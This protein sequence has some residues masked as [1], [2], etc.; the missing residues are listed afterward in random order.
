MINIYIGQYKKNRRLNKFN[1]IRY[2]TICIVLDY[3]CYMTTTQN[4]PAVTMDYLTNLVFN[5]SSFKRTSENT[6]MIHTV[7]FN[8]NMM[9]LLEMVQQD[10]YAITDAGKAAYINQ[11]YH[12]VAANLYQSKA[13]Q[14]LSLIAI[15][16]ALVGVFL[17]IFLH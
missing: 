9:G 10:Y 7:I 17:S 6:T 1:M 16:I 5:Q 3:F 14:K 2:T 4:E 8:M 12:I 15:V 11:S 13:S